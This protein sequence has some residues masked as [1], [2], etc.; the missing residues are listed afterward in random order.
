MNFGGSIM[1]LKTETKPTCGGRE[2]VA[3]AIW[4]L[5]QWRKV[6]KVLRLPYGSYGNE[7]RQN[8]KKFTDCHM[9]AMAMPW[10]GV[11]KGPRYGN[12]YGNRKSLST[13]Y[14]GLLLYVLPYLTYLSIYSPYRVIVVVVGGIYVRF[15]LYIPLAM[16]TVPMALREGGLSHV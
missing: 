5:W 13:I 7:N 12:G 10:G 9:A 6:V 15:Y 4:Q 1:I 14:I 16:A 3:I 11:A 2:S 8:S